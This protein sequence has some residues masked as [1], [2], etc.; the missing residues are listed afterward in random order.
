MVKI[1]STYPVRQQ[2]TS[3]RGQVK[4]GLSCGISKSELHGPLSSSAAKCEVG[5][6]LPSLCLSA[7]KAAEM[8]RQEQSK[9]SVRAPTSALQAPPTLGAGDFNECG[10][11]AR[12][13]FS[14][15]RKPGLALCCSELCRPGSG[16]PGTPQG[17]FNGIMR[18]YQISAVLS[19]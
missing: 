3:S 19:L 1:K 12:C 6:L 17:S 8:F 2:A 11:R 4:Q 13:A 18:H 5:G 10:F 7:T 16:S 9:A 15:C 14:L